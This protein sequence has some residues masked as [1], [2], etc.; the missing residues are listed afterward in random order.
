MNIEEAKRLIIGSWDR[1]TY[2]EIQG[3]VN[4]YSFD[5]TIHSY[6]YSPDRSYNFSRPYAIVEKERTLYLQSGREQIEL[7]AISEKCMVLQG[8]SEVLQEQSEW[9]IFGRTRA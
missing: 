1:R 5:R 8:Q 2:P 9:D 4:R 7:I 6:E 3:R